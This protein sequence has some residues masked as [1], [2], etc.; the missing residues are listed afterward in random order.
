ML[1][2]KEDGTGAAWI[3]TSTMPAGEAKLLTDID[4]G[5]K[6]GMISSFDADGFTVANS[7]GVSNDDG[8]VYYYVAWEADADVDVSSFT[9]AST[10]AISIDVGYQPAMVWLLGGA[11][12]WDEKSPGQYLMDGQDNAATFQFNNG[13]ELTTASY[14][15]LDFI[16]ADG[17]DTRAA[18][19]SGT[20]NGPGVGIEYHYVT[21]KNGSDVAT[22]SY[23]GD[24]GTAQD[25]T[26]TVEPD[27][28]MVK[29][30][31]GGDNS[32]FKTTEMEATESFKFTAAAATNS[33]TGFSNS[34]KEFSVGTNG[35]V[36]GSN[37]YD[38]F[39]GAALTTL[40]VELLSFKGSK[41]ANGNL[42]FWKTGSEINS[43]HFYVE[44]SLD[45]ETFE[46]IGY[47]EAAGNSFEAINYSFID[48]S[49][50]NN[51]NYYRLVQVDLDGTTHH[52]RV[53]VIN[54]T[55]GNRVIRAL[56][57]PNGNRSGFDIE[58]TGVDPLSSV[59]VFNGSGQLLHSESFSGK[60]TSLKKSIFLNAL[61][62]GVYF[63]K[64]HYGVNSVQT[65]RFV[66][67]R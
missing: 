22:G 23:T 29:N 3:A 7:H 44:R 67:T 47:V 41:T 33:I 52:K 9:P 35:E 39:V 16:D 53:I 36:N 13:G 50:S 28:V 40:P 8:V 30:T 27:F 61:Q 42:L 51:N 65:V 21:F 34:P 5:P 46:I 64:F 18:T 14:E 59:E 48:E 66:K 31:N 20:H 10:G 56:A 4:D 32:W 62:H 11:E 58:Y 26:I 17:F 43:S 6:S 55:T 45:G 15:I 37:T 63:V 25:V 49:P 57:Y 12:N 24:N 38:Y 54:G 60:T 2:V 19:N 1:L